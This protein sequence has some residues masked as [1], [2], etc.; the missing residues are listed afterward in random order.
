[1]YL[2]GGGG[3]RLHWLSSLGLCLSSAGNDGTLMVAL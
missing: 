1:M 3:F 2:D